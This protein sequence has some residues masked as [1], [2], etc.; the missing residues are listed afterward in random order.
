MFAK[1]QHFFVAILFQ[2]T[3]EKEVGQFEVRLLI[4]FF[5]L[6]AI[7]YKSLL[8]YKRVQ[9]ISIQ[10]WH[11]ISMQAEF[12]TASDCSWYAILVHMTLKVRH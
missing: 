9:M 12:C 1:N 6:D 2:Y 10:L 8:C 11:R 3:H 7:S 4:Q 5:G